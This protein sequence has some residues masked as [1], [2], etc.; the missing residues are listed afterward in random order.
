MKLEHKAVDPSPDVS[1]E[2]ELLVLNEDGMLWCTAHEA[3]TISIEHIREEYERYCAA[4][5]GSA[6]QGAAK[7]VLIELAQRMA[8][9]STALSSA[10]PVLPA[11]PERREQ[12]AHSALSAL[13]QFGRSSIGLAMDI[14]ANRRS[15]QA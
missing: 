13:R 4:P 8:Q 10:N 2:I 6:E 14:L 11:K 15:R 7:L 5:E 3:G 1:Q 12:Q 9:G